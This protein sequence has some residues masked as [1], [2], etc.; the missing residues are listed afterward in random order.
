MPD[1]PQTIDALQAAFGERDYV[2]DRALMTSVFLGLS[3]AE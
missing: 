2:A 1:H 3:S